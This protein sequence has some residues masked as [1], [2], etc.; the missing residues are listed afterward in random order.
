MP[1]KAK[2]TRPPETRPLSREAIGQAIRQ[3]PK[4]L[5]NI[6][7]DYAPL[8]DLFYMFRE[9]INLRALTDDGNVTTIL[10]A[11]DQWADDLPITFTSS[12]D[13]RSKTTFKVDVMDDYASLADFL[14]KR[15]VVCHSILTEL[16][17]NALVLAL[18][19]RIQGGR[20]ILA[21]EE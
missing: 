5:V 4:V 19:E 20:M 12:R 9:K 16:D 15:V 21:E 7:A 11:F 18:R 17:A 1:A 6:I 13:P 8:P 14:I 3:M 10:L 2:I